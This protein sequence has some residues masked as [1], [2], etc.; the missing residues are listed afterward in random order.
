MS[1]A[2]IAGIISFKLANQLIIANHRNR[3]LNARQKRAHEICAAPKYES[4][5]AP[6]AIEAMRNADVRRRVIGIIEA[7]SISRLCPTPSINMGCPIA[8]WPASSNIDASPSIANNPEI[9]AK[10]SICPCQNR[11]PRRYRHAL[12]LIESHRHL[13][14]NRGLIVAASKAA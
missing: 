6:S 8:S 14:R 1:P 3:L 5:A 7:C 2:S 12:M 13:R 9:L 11:Y 4:Q 10:R